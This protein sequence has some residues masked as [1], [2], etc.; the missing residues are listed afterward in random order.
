M[1]VTAGDSRTKSAETKS[2]PSSHRGPMA[3]RTGGALGCWGD[4][5]YRFQ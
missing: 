1:Q 4:R 5:R 3:S 2:A